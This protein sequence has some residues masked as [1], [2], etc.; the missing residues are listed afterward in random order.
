MDC[1]PQGETY[2]ITELDRTARRAI[3][4]HKKVDYYTKT[5][6]NTTVD[7][8]GVVRSSLNLRLSWGPAR[9]RTVVWGFKKIQERRHRAFEVVDLALPP[10][11]YETQGA[12]ID[13]D[14]DTIVCFTILAGMLA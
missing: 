8:L 5:R 10:W 11:E 2:L 7:A 14:E 12:W 4:V 3:A 1:P 9:V 13:L 6:D